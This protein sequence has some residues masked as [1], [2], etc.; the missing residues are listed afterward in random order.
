MVIT[1]LHLI[2]FILFIFWMVVMY[3]IINHTSEKRRRD[4]KE[5]RT[6]WP[7]YHA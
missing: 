5:E 1:F 2:I 7:F 6:R 4:A 3:G